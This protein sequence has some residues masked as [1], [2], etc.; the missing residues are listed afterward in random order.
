M[1]PVIDEDGTPDLSPMYNAGL[2]KQLAIR[3]FD[4][5]K[6]YLWPVPTK[7]ILINSNLTQNPN[8]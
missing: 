6:Q 4:A 3:S 5:S 8:Y 1:T 7:E 2:I